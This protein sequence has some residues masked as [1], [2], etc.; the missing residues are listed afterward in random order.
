MAHAL[1]VRAASGE[2]WPR[3]PLLRYLPGVE[4]TSTWQSEGPVGRDPAGGSAGPW[5][6]RRPDTTV[7]AQRRDPGALAGDR[8]PWSSGVWPEGRSG[9][10]AVTSCVRSS[11]TAARC[12]SSSLMVVSRLGSRGA[13]RALRPAAGHRSGR[14]YLSLPSC[15]RPSAGARSRSAAFVGGPALAV[16]PSRAST[17]PQESYTGPVAPDRGSRSHFPIGSENCGGSSAGCREVAGN[18]QTSHRTST[19]C[20]QAV[21][22]ICHDRRARAGRSAHPRQQGDLGLIAPQLPVVA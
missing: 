6:G 13:A 17:S 19:G 7:C 15:T 10:G 12:R 9:L 20:P 18:S 21:H 14:S 1:P 16:P 2:W 5:P 8:G 22:R 4:C 11:A 3:P